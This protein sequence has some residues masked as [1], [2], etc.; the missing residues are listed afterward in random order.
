[1]ERLPFPVFLKDGGFLWGLTGPHRHIYRYQADYK[2]LGPVT[3]G[4]WD[5]RELHGVNEKSGE[6]YFTANERNPIGNDL[7]AAALDG[8]SMRRLTQEKV[9]IRFAERRFQP[10]HRYLEQSQAS[11]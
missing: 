10:L 7:Y 5:V 1:V 8:K 4:E 2:L 6:V 9:R 3:K 11:A